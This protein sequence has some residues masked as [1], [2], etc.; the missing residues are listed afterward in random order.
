MGGGGPMRTTTCANEAAGNSVKASSKAKAIF[1][2]MNQFLLGLSYL[3]CVTGIMQPFRPMD[4]SNV[5]R[6]K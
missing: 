5:V 4:E 2:T 6:R 3:V 1:F